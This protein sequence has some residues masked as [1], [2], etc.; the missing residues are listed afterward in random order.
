MTY[1]LHH[2]MAFAR[3]VDI[4]ETK[5]QGW[6][7]LAYLW[8]IKAPIM[9]IVFLP[10]WCNRPTQSRPSVSATPI[11][12]IEPTAHTRPC[13]QKTFSKENQGFHW[14]PVPATYIV[15]L[16]IGIKVYIDWILQKESAEECR[17]LVMKDLHQHFSE[18][19]LHRHRA[20]L[21]SLSKD[22]H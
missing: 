18:F 13:P 22:Y 9:L 6:W 11:S 16:K 2:C 20:S 7:C 3:S 10:S 17:Q 15:R 4:V 5:R 1:H 8:T 19:I 14:I 12:L 21:W